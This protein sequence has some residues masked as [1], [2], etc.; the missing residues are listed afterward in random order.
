VGTMRVSVLAP[1][2]PTAP[3]EIA[4]HVVE[5]ERVGLDLVWVGEPY[6]FDAPTT[7]GYLAA[8]TTTVQVGAGILPI[9]TR[10]PSLVAMTAAGLD[11]ISGG[12]AVLG[13]GTSGPQVIEGFHGV[14]FDRPV[15]RTR[16]VIEICRRVWRRE[17]PLVHEGSAY[18]VPLPASH[19]TGLGKPLKLLTKPVRP[20]IPIYVAALG[21]KNVEL[22]AEVADGWNP[23]FFSPARARET[24]GKPL[25]AGATRRDAVLGPLEICAGGLVAI[26]DDAA[27]L[28][29]LARPH[30]AL[31]VEG[32]G[33]RG[34]NFY[35]EL[36]ARYG[37]EREAHEI[38]EHFL[39]GRR[40]DAEVA[41][42][43]AFLEEITLCGS[44]AYVKDRL[45][46]YQEAG[47]T[48]LNADLA[49]PNPVGT[50]AELKALL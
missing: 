46:E 44:R 19:G 30:V 28:R 25:E 22:A 3:S 41:I 35:N 6:G 14:P 20:E 40:H 37:Y 45:A 24:W 4:R 38:Q 50:L 33:A 43:E 48:I 49:G 18:Q 23:L 39:E 17:Q 16:E 8:Q 47:V 26:G 42:P 2:A 12:R 10:T 5:L 32:M 36:F 31:Y 27:A 34:H 21:E 13:L 11:W 9:Y 15:A 1:S 7:L 29:D